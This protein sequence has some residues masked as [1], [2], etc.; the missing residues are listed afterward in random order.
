[1]TEQN[2]NTNPSNSTK[3]VLNVVIETSYQQ[4]QLIKDKLRPIFI[5]LNTLKKKPE[6]MVSELIRENGAFKN[7]IGIDFTY[8]KGSDKNLVIHL[9]WGKY[10][11]LNNEHDY[12]EL[13]DTCENEHKIE[14]KKE[15]NLEQNIVFITKFFDEK[16]S[17][18]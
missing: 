16:L 13:I 11:K 7:Y 8:K 1:M 18:L 2:L 17:S 10:D 15:F 3:P 5:F 4:K 12:F 14:L 6:N 9:F